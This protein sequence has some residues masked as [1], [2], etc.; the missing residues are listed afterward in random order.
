MHAVSRSFVLYIKCM[1]KMRG[2]YN[3]AGHLCLLLLFF[4]IDIGCFVDCA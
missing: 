2:C 4:A 3:V 1:L